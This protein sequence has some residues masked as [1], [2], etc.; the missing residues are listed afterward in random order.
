MPD[1]SEPQVGGTAITWTA[2]SNYP[3]QDQIRYRF[4]VYDG[5]W[6][7]GRDWARSNSWTWTPSDTGDY[8]VKVEVCDGMDSTVSVGN[9]IYREYSISAKNS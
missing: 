9:A 3:D 7:V 2:C 8:D 1:K 5:G 6:N 4:W